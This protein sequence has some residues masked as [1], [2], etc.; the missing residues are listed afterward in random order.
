[1]APSSPTTRST[2]T[3]AGCAASW[4]RS[5]R[6]RRSAPPA[7]SGTRSCRR[8]RVSTCTAPRTLRGPR[9]SLLALAVIAAWLVVL[10]AGFAFLLVTR[11]TARWTTGC[12]SGPRPRRRPSSSAQVLC[13]DVRESATDSELDSNI[14]VF[15]AAP[16]SCAPLRA[17]V[18]AGGRGAAAGRR[19]GSSTGRPQFYV[20]PVVTNRAVVG[21]IVASAD[22]DPF[23]RTRDTALVGVGSWRCCS[24]SAPFRCSA[25]PP[26]GRCARSTR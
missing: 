21:S 3:S 6:R 16:R 9:I 19:R 20:L 17:E 8:A 14:W 13:R 18:P 7:A 2:S 26:H 10:A 5:A 12:G 11:L 15:G 1:M 22:L 23:E 24:C 4:S 25:S